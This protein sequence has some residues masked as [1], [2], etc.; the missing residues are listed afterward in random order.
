M[1]TV[2][3]SV[4]ITYLVTHGHTLS[5]SLSSENPGLI[6]KGLVKLDYLTRIFAQA[7]SPLF[8][9]LLLSSG[10]L[11]RVVGSTRKKGFG[12]PV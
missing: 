5:W 3:F 11:G 6:V 8:F 2:C 4:L 10:E 1:V 9:L 7:I 12:T